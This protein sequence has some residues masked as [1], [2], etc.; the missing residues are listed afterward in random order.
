MGSPATATARVEL[1]RALD[2]DA[3]WHAR[4]LAVL[5]GELDLMDSL[6][7]ALLGA[8][9]EPCRFDRLARDW[10]AQAITEGALHAGDLAWVVPLL[11][12][13]GAGCRHD[14]DRLLLLMGHRGR[15]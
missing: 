5:L 3:Y 2:A 7:L 15:Q 9:K 8:R 12:G 13:T 6:R 10:I 4:S 14:G 1:Q 11:H